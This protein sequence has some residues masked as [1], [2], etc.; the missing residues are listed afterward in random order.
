VLKETTGRELDARAM[1]EYFQPL[2]EW[3][4]TQNRGRAATLPEL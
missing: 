3:L 1:V 2:Y 4:K